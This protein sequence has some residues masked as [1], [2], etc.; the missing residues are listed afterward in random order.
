M[1]VTAHCCRATCKYRVTGKMPDLGLK[2]LQY[3]NIS[4]LGILGLILQSASSMREVIQYSSEFLYSHGP[5]LVLSMN[6]SDPL[7]E[8]AIDIHFELQPKEQVPKKQT[9]GNC[10]GTTHRI[11]K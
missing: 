9:I 11:F 3:Q 1:T 4:T 7:Y 10:L 5:S 6:E 2:I 8:N